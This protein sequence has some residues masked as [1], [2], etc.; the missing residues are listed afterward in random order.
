MSVFN[1][2]SES[3]LKANCASESA[4]FPGE[5]PPASLSL[6]LSLSAEE[7]LLI[8]D[9]GLNAGSLKV[10]QAILPQSRIFVCP[11]AV[12]LFAWKS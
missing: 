5:R 10:L 11:N 9:G 6:P 1:S 12:R 8:Y 7:F 2:Q 4:E 3:E